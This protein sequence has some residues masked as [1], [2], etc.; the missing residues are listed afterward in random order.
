MKKAEI[1]KVLKEIMN[2]NP[3]IVRVAYGADDDIHFVAKGGLIHVY[4]E[5]LEVG[6]GPIGQMDPVCSIALK[7]VKEV[8]LGKHT[9]GYAL[10]VYFSD[11][12]NFFNVIIG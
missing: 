3:H 12:G 1:I 2:E 9:Y 10:H 4:D 7:D 11:D 5:L 6:H 8:A